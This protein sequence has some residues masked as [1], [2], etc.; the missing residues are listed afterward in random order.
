MTNRV[1]K[2]IALSTLIAL[3]AFAAPHAAF[4][5]VAVDKL[6]PTYQQK[7]KVGPIY[8]FT[9]ALTPEQR[10]GPLPAFA[11][12]KLR[13]PEGKPPAALWDRGYYPCTMGEAM[14]QVPKD[15][16]AKDWAH[17]TPT[18]VD[19]KA[20]TKGWGDP[21]TDSWKELNSLGGEYHDFSRDVLANLSAGKHTM[22]IWHQLNYKAWILGSD[23]YHF[24]DDR[25]IA[26]AKTSFE[27]EVL[28]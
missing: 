18:W 16:A 11:L 24:W 6:V 28:P 13:F 15:H 12:T 25:Y 2:L 1:F 27:I 7:G 8:F 22:T 14:A 17:A 23:G 10:K 21:V 20:V 3:P 4:Q 19:G 26:L 9:Q 5:P